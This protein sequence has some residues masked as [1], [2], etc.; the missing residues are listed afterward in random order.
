MKDFE[1]PAND[2][3]SVKL[4][5][6]HAMIDNEANETRSYPPFTTYKYREKEGGFIKRTID[7]MF[8][9]KEQAKRVEVTGWLEPP[10]DD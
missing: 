5:A 6:Y 10:S 7:Y 8:M 3:D 1:Y 2:T 9:S 4:D